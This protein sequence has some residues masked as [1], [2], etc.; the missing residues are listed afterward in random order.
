MVDLPEKQLL[1]KYNANICLTDVSHKPTM[2]LVHNA[3]DKKKIKMEQTY[4]TF[5]TYQALYE[6]QFYAVDTISIIPRHR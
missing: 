6:V 5:I 3:R 1:Y 2:C 4:A